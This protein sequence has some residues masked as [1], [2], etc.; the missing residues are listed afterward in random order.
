MISEQI[1][2]QLAMQLFTCFEDGSAIAPITETYPALTIADAYA[3]Q[4]VLLTHH[5]AQGRRVVGRK[6]GATSKEVQRLVGVD[7]P[8]YGVLFDAFTFENGVSLSRSA[9]RMVSPRIEAEL[10]FVLKKDIKGPGVTSMQLLACIDTIFPVFEIVDSRIRDWKIKIVDT[11]ADN[12]SSWGIVLG[13]QAIAP[14]G[15]DL[16]TVGMVLE[17][18]GEIIRTG[19][20][21]AVLGHPLT[22]AIWLVNT[23]GA[24]DETLHAGDLLLTG[25]LAAL[26]DATP[27]RFRARFS[28]GLGAVEFVLNE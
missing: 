17:Q 26:A 27:G 4:R 2:Q 14:F 28:D 9:Q 13:K 10:G 5:L 3:I 16:S 11:I 18:D 12:S 1:V 7:Q 15:V 23:L 22:S 8:D 19:V 21:A 24:Y 25:S 20:G 6:I